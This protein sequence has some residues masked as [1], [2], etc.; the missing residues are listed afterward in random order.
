MTGGAGL[1]YLVE[2]TVLIA[3]Y[4]D[5]EDPLEM[6]AFLSFFPDFLPAAAEIMGITGL[7]GQFH[8]IYIRIGDHQYVPGSP[9]NN[10][11]RDQGI[12]KMQG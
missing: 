12:D 8:G 1:L 2:E 4:Q 5:A 9:V 10:D 6:A 7:S 11:D 3:V